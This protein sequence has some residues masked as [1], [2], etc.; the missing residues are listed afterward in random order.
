MGATTIAPGSA[1]T[2]TRSGLKRA[3][4]GEGLAEARSNL[5]GMISH[6]ILP[7]EETGLNRTVDVD[8]DEGNSVPSLV[9]VARSRS[10]DVGD[11]GR[12]PNREV[13]R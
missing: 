6:M 8:A 5:S 2:M 1:A 10:R 12:D 7:T 13:K 4:A 9:R 3:N 11:T